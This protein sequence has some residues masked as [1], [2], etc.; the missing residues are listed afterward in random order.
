[1]LHHLPK[2]IDSCFMVKIRFGLDDVTPH[3]DFFDGGSGE[4]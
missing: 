1:M 2:F 4:D 3:A